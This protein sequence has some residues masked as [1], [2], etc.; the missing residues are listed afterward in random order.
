MGGLLNKSK[1][2]KMFLT[3]SKQA[4]MNL[5]QPSASAHLILLPLPPAAHDAVVR[6]RPRGGAQQRPSGTGDG[7]VDT[8]GK[9]GRGHL[10]RE[11]PWTG[12]KDV[13]FG[14]IRWGCWGARLKFKLIQML[15]IF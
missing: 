15:T 10:H 7:D 6:G 9:A 13:R 14:K 1:Y 11:S 3:C 8:S 12:V 4:S 2:F 5:L